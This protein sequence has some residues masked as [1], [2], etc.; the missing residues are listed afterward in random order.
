MDLAL[1]VRTFGALGLILGVLFGALWL[2]RRYD[3]RLPGAG[4]FGQGRQRR[5]KIVERID[6][7]QRRY[8][9]LVRRD[10]YE[11]LLLV[12]PNGI[13]VLEHG[14]PVSQN[15]ADGSVPAERGNESPSFR[16]SMIHRAAQAAKAER[17]AFGARTELEAAE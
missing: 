6:L 9:L 4:G 14:I 8:L 12:R 5:M 3:L 10:N 1:I 16:A 2:V 15:N 13:L 7:D 17:R 11:H